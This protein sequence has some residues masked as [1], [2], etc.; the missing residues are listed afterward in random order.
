M[1]TI[2]FDSIQTTSISVQPNEYRSYLYTTARRP[3]QADFF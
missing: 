3:Y 2:H 1:V